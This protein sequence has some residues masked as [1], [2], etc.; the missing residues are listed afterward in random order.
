MHSFVKEISETLILNTH[1][2]YSLSVNIFD[3]ILTFC[4][5]CIMIYELHNRDH[6]YALRD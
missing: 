3:F 5:L 6:Q 1:I 2:S 4:G